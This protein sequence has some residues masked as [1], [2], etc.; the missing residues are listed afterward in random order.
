M[1]WL[2]FATVLR[3]KI[4][5]EAFSSKLLPFAQF[6]THTLLNKNKNGKKADTL[7]WAGGQCT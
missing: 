4:T 3:P 6:I 5:M 7:M 1:L 2:L